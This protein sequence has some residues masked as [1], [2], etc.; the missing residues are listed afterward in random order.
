MHF[1]M[2][3]LMFILPTFIKDFGN[4]SICKVKTDKADAVKIARYGI[5]YWDDIKPYSPED[6]LH[7]LLKN[8]SRHYACFVKLRTAVK[9]KLTTLIEL[10]FLGI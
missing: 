7:L 3:D 1:L 5:N 6:A 8:Y 9:N 2:P 10:S 4:N